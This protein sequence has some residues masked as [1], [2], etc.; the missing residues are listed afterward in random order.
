MKDNYGKRTY[1]CKCGNIQEEY[2]WE[3]ELKLGRFK[4][5][6]CSAV[7]NYVNLQKKAVN[8]SAAIRTPTKNR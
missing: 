7:L 2:A 5:N 1:K 6:S 4:C 8:Q 3:K